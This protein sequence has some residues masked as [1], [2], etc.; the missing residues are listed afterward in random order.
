MEADAD[1]VH[2]FSGAMLAKLQA[3]AHKAHW[4]EVTQAWL[5]GRLIQ[6]VSELTH[7]LETGHPNEIRSECADVANFALMIADNTE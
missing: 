1:A 4:S 5:L 3:N 7:A 6:E 2:R